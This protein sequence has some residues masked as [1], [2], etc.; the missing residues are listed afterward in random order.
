VSNKFGFC[1]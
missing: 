1:V